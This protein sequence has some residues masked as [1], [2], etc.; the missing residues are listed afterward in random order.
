M[1]CKEEYKIFYRQMLKLF[2]SIVYLYP[3]ISFYVVPNLFTLFCITRI[4]Y[5]EK[6]ED[7]IRTVYV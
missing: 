7:Q 5:G 6:R 4:V 3:K 2:N 1:K